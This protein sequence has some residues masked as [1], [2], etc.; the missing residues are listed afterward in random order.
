MPLIELYQD[1]I[2]FVMWLI[3]AVF[4]TLIILNFRL[5]I[6]QFRKIKK[7]T[8][9]YLG[10][11]F[12]TGF[13]LRLFVFPHFHI[14]YIDEPWY[15]EMAKNM[16][17][18]KGP[19][20]CEYVDYEVQECFLPL[21][22][23]GWP[24]L[25]SIVFLLLGL[26]NY[27]A[28]YLSSILGSLSVLLIFMLTY[29][30]F[31]NKNAA[32]WSAFFLALT[33]L[34][35]IWSNSAE[36]NTA[37]V[38]FVL[39]TMV[40]FFVY[41]NGKKKIILVLTSLSLLLTIMIRFENIVL[42]GLF[43]LG[44]L[45]FSKPFSKS[46]PG[47]IFKA[48]YPLIVVAILFA[49]IFFESLF[50]RIF[51]SAILSIDHYYLNL[52][53]FLRVSSFNYIYLFL[54]A[55]CFFLPGKKIKSR[56]TYLVTCFLVFFVLYLP[57]FS[58][59]RMALVPMLFILILS[60]NFIGKLCRSIRHEAFTIPLIII[61]LTMFGL[62]L[63]STYDHIQ[64]RYKEQMLETQAVAELRDS[65]PNECY[66]IAER[67]VVFTSISDIKGIRT[68]TA[69]DDPE[70][71]KRLL[72]KTCVY[73]FYDGYCVDRTISRPGGSRERCGK[74]MRMFDCNREKEFERMNVR[75]YLYRINGLRY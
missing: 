2:F 27:Y 33:P 41:V 73:Y 68:S 30:I 9:F 59:D 19:V 20:V 65:V 5:L 44:Y 70:M 25:V 71:I 50:F 63:D 60:S 18:G 56:I 69:L 38:F 4:I 64:G 6:R 26:N 75:Y 54:A 40:L 57:L 49:M 10:I 34:Q 23:P 48:F 3:F 13:V 36:T 51:R 17:Q 31:K 47:Q 67:P 14:M 29:L 66:L 24:F 7:N 22:P 8:W 53:E 12:L 15:M 32:I 35:V 28:L 74:M 11:I 52:F 43:I 61:F 16:N 37:S 62:G 1:N 39:L 21:K 72:S 58:E 46:F 42:I 55:G 45:L